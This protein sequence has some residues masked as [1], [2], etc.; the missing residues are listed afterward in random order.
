MKFTSSRSKRDPIDISMIP[1]VDLFLN[2]LI[3]FLVSTSFN[4]E[5]AFFVQ[6]PE[7]SQEKGS[8][9]T[10][11][12]FI[13]MDRSG[14]V[15]INQKL[16][17]EAGLEAALKAFPEAQR[18]AMPVVVRA[19]KNVPHGEVVLLLDQVRRTGYQNIGMATVEKRP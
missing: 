18:K 7:A 16:V 4:E 8:S 3:F 2:I 5:S 15:S 9:Q 10:K 6:L 1:L 14:K 11:Q 12:L 17:A 19:D 13:S